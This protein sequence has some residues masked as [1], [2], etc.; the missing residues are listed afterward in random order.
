MIMN[1]QRLFIWPPNPTRWVATAT[2]QVIE[3]PLGMEIY[4][5]EYIVLSD[6][7]LVI[8]SLIEQGATD[9]W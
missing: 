2:Q 7:I 1:V 8:S 4:V 9:V 6:V 3:H 5:E